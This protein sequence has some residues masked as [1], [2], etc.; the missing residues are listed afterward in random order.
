MEEEE[1]GKAYF[2][3]PASVCANTG[4]HRPRSCDFE[5]VSLIKELIKEKLHA[6]RQ[7]SEKRK[8]RGSGRKGADLERRSDIGSL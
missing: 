8:G 6:A 3:S 7:I 2:F 1:E 5:V 4:R